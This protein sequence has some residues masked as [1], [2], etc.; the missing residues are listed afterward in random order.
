MVG[1]FFSRRILFIQKIIHGIPNEAKLASLAYNGTTA[2]MEWTE[3]PWVSFLPT[4]R[5]PRSL[6]SS[7]PPACFSITNRYLRLHSLKI[8]TLD[9]GPLSARETS[10]GQYS[11]G[12]HYCCEKGLLSSEVQVFSSKPL[13][14]PKTRYGAAFRERHGWKGRGKDFCPSESSYIFF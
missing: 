4:V 9:Q 7:L 11:Q 12:Q 14:M 1:I 5:L 3:S 13:G 6:L 2:G 10:P 8:P